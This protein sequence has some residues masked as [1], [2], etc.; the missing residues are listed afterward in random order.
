MSPPDLAANAPVP[1]V[2]QPLRVNLFPVR[3]KKADEMISHDGERFFRLR[4]T[5]K[6]LL[7]NPRF[8]WH[9]AP[10]TE[11]DIVLV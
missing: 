1:N 11:T 9:I 10:L 4:V 6:P 2:L 7:A 5:Q 8:Y 3:G